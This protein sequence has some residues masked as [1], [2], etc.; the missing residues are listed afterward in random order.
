MTNLQNKNEQNF[1]IFFYT[2]QNVKKFFALN[3][4]MVLPFMMLTALLVS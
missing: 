2:K 3:K 1:F 4:M